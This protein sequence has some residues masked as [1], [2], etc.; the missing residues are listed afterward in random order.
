LFSPFRFPLICLCHLTRLVSA[1]CV[2]QFKSV[3]RKRA[4]PRE[5]G[6]DAPVVVRR[7]DRNAN[8]PDKPN[9]R[10]EVLTLPRRHTANNLFRSSLPAFDPY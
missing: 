4:A 5:D 7:S 9:Y 1:R 2:S 10:Y 8:N 3:K 6:D